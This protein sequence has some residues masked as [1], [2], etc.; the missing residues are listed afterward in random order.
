MGRPSNKEKRTI[1]VLGIAYDSRARLRACAQPL[2]HVPWARVA[3]AH[4]ASPDESGLNAARAAL[5]AIG[6]VGD[7]V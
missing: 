7:T 2:T 1:D 5:G 4:N 3:A 6:S